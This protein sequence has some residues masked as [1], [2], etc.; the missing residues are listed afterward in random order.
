M[1]LQNSQGGEGKYVVMDMNN[2]QVKDT[3]IHVHIMMSQSQSRIAS[4]VTCRLQG[5]YIHVG[6]S[7]YSCWCVWVWG[8]H[9]YGVCMNMGWV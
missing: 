3:H 9:R 8:G 6:I 1:A 5:G 7:V 4:M 2:E